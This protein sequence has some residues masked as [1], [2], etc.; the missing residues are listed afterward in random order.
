MTAYA[1]DSDW[2][3][4]R[5]FIAQESG[6]VDVDWSKKCYKEQTCQG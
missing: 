5:S 2:I 1:F 3:R 6:G 4:L